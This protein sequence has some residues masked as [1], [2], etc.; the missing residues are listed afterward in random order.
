M[1]E[2]AVF[3]T[4]MSSI[5]IAVAAQTTARVQ[6]WVVVKVVAPGSWGRKLGAC[7]RPAAGRT[8]E[9]PLVGGY[10]SPHVARGAE[11]VVGIPAGLHAREALVAGA[12]GRAH[13]VRAL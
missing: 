10:G 9:E 6:R 11:H 7:W 4:A 2:S 1:S 12:E 3:T 13:A 5:S 8:A